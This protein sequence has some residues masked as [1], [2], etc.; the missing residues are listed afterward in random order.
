MVSD[1]LQLQLMVVVRFSAW[2]ETELRASG[3]A[4]SERLSRSE[5]RTVYSN[6]ERIV[7][8]IAPGG[9]TRYNMSSLR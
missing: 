2:M 1:P 7:R 9:A 3:R 5:D 6:G 4:E 8:G